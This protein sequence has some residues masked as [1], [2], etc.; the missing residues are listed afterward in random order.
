MPRPHPRPTLLPTALLL[1]ALAGAQAAPPD[2]GQ[3][4]T[5]AAAAVNGV[6]RNCPASFSR[7]GTP[8]KQ[9]VGAPGTT[10]QVRLQLGAAL[11]SDLYGVWRSRD[12][13]RSVYNWLRTPGGFVYLRL[14]PDPDGR[15][16][17]LVYLDTPPDPLPTA[18]TPA[19][20][21]TPVQ[22]PAPQAPT[23]Q[24]AAT[25]PAPPPDAATRTPQAP[26][27]AP[28]PFRRPLSL[29]TP[30]LNGPDVLAV[31]NR[32]IH[33]MRPVRTGHGDGWFGPVTAA[34][35]RAFQA[36]NRLP[37]TG[38]VDRATWERLFAADA[39]TFT[40]PPAP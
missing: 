1:S 7:V 12:E 33:L 24:P 37:V 9:C 27:A 30:R 26:T 4:A 40:P 16:R 39:A 3:A 23:P 31:Q 29:Q 18:P 15:A 32:L 8:A 19:V 17:T 38:R 6:L 20:T 35:V 11:G 10:E 13:Q 5:R 28:L 22:P 14:Q 25:Q 21:L 36:G 34:T 2:L